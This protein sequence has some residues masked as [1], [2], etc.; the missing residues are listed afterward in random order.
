M[1]WPAPRSTPQLSPGLESLSPTTMSLTVGRGLVSLLHREPAS[2][3]VE[4]ERLAIE[5]T[6]G[7]RLGRSRL[8]RGQRGR[9]GRI[10]RD[11]NLDR[12]GLSGWRRP[13]QHQL[14]L[15][16]APGQ[17]RGQHGEAGAR[18]AR[19]AGRHQDEDVLSRF[20]R[21]TLAPRSGQC[22]RARAKCDNSAAGCGAA[23]SLA[24]RA[25]ARAASL[26]PADP[27]TMPRRGS[28]SAVP[29]SLYTRRTAGN[30]RKS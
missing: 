5:R 15:G 3:A 10:G 28:C 20:M 23:A 16:R 13:R 25:H 7:Q 27:A 8:A 21:G 26:A 11:G 2:A 12:A 24:R 30:T 29:L 18:A 22:E 9:R 4:H 17:G 1:G 6:L 19:R 14:G